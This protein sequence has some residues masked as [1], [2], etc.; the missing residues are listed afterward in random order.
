M[1]HDIFAICS[2]ERLILIFSAIVALGIGARI[3]RGI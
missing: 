2:L 3:R 1:S